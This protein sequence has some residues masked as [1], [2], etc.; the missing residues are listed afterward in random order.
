VLSRGQFEFTSD[1]YHQVTEHL[2]SWRFEPLRVLITNDDGIESPGLRSLA[3]MALLRGHEVLVAAPCWDASGASS[4]VTG[5][6]ND[7][8]VVSEPRRWPGWSDSSVVAVDATP[9]LIALY[10]LHEKFGPPPD[11]VLSGIN[12]GANTGRSVLHSG[13]VGAAFTA[14]QHNCPAIAVSSA[15]VD[16]ASTAEVHWATAAEVAGRVLDWLVDDLRCVV[17]NCN[18]P[19][20]P[21]ER[22]LGTQ[23]GRLAEVGTSQTSLTEASGRSAAVTLGGGDESSEVASDAALV[24]QGYACVTAL[25]PVVE[26]PRID[27]GAELGLP[28]LVSSAPTG[29]LTVGSSRASA[30]LG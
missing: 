30:E 2:M 24:E 19:D 22:L 5:V 16:M 20:V 7:G 25:R 8:T 11:L 1:G 28:T 15:V 23:V 12:R 4:S 13:T 6:S 10:A 29:G 17:V 18:I 26:D 14:F 21:P 27:L 3:D 9:A